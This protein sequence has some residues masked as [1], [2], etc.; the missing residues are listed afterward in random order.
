MRAIRVK[1]PF[2]QFTHGILGLS[3]AQAEAR[4]HVLEPLGD[5]RYQ[6]LQPTQFKRGEVLRWDG[7]IT[8]A[9]EPILELAVRKKKER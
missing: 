1:G 8:P 4:R 5:G 2:A 6:L 3:P 7:E 9:L